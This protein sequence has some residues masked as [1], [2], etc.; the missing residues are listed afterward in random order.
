SV[1]MEKIFNP[2]GFARRLL[3]ASLCFVVAGCSKEAPDASHDSTA[4]ELA[5]DASSAGELPARTT[6]AGE[7]PARPVPAGELPARPALPLKTLRDVGATG[8]GADD[9]TARV[10]RAIDAADVSCI[11]GEGRTYLVRGAIRTSKSICFQNAHLVQDQDAIDI[12][13]YIRS[14]EL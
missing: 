4:G 10:Q 9:D 12:R 14:T 11:D 1:S 6:P 8:N 2:D 7:L 5:L 3:A 13:P